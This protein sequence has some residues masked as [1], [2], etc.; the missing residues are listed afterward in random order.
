ML[1]IFALTLAAGRAPPPP[2]SLPGFVDTAQLAAMCDP[3]ADDHGVG[4]VLCAGYVIGS[5]DQILAQQSRRILVRRTVCPPAEISVEQLRDR[6]ASRLAGLTGS[7]P[8]AA[9]DLVRRAA[10]AEFPCGRPAA[11]P[12]GP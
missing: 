9:S 6:V 4:Q 12:G 3:H 8:A 7:R 5:I 1:W 2:P 11:G 10:E